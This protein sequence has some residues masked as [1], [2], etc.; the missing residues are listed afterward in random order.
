MKILSIVFQKPQIYWTLG[1][2]LAYMLLVIIISGFYSTIPLILKYSATINWIELSLSL[3][4]SLLIGFL[5]AVNAVY[6][7]HQYQLRIQCKEGNAFASAGTLGGLAAGVCP[8]CVT[9]LF[10]LILGA[11]GVSFSFATLPF[12]GLEVQVLSIA[13]LLIGL[14]FFKREK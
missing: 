5:V 6:A 2:F 12:K 8:L 3:A 4:F 1:I 14:S 11:F 10:P 9:G 7:Y 13:L